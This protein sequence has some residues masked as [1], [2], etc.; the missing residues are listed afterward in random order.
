MQDGSGTTGLTNL[1]NAIIQDKIFK[2]KTENIQ[3]SDNV[4]LRTKESLHYYEIFRKYN[5]APTKQPADEKNCPN[6][7]FSVEPNSK[8]CRM[9]GS[10]PI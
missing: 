8:F 5:D 7:N 2:T 9:C 1:F 3:K 10:Y 4:K 6:C